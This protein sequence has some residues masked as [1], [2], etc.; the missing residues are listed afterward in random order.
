MPAED[1]IITGTFTI[2]KYTITYIIDN[3]TY[4]TEEVEY[5]STITPPNPGEREGYDFTWGDYPSTMP[6]NDIIIYV[7]LEM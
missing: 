5:G 3:E 4:K 7:F 6:A 1:V 2:N